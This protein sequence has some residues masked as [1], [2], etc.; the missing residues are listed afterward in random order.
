M[1]ISALK[2]FIDVAK[3]HPFPIQNLPYGIFSS[4]NNSNKRAGVAIGDFVLDLSLLEE[5]G[6]LDISHDGS[7]VFDQPHLN[8]FMAMGK[9]IWRQVR[10]CITQLLSH[11]NPA[12]RDNSPLRRVALVPMT[13]VTMHLPAKIG[14]Y[15][16]FYSSEYHASNV[17][18]MIRGSGNALQ[19][20]WKHLPVAYHGRASSVVLSGEAIH[21]P[22]GQIRPKDEEAPFVSPSQALD[23]EL[24]MA[25][26]TGQGNLLGHPI[27]IDEAE[28]KIFGLVLMNDWSA[29]DIQKWEYV[30]LG[31][32]LGK[33][34]ATSIS[35]WI[36]T[37]DAL[38]PFR[39]SGPEQSPQPLKY[40][41]QNKASSFDIQLQVDLA[42][43][44]GAEMILCESNFKYL[45]WSMAQQLA[46][47]TING[48]N[49]QPGDLLGSGTV[50]GPSE[51]S[52]GCLLE[53]SLK[54][55]ALPNGESRG[56]L[57]DG[58]RVTM[59]GWCQGDDYRV[60][61]GELIGTVLPSLK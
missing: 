28:D 32:F 10:E 17:G 40:L 23:F 12:L 41:Q 22:C 59:R 33:S 53:H 43:N 8:N 29:R 31:P 19:P 51:R 38:E 55:I 3:E 24:E 11:D 46:H 39:I 50:S 16:D 15:T 27:T 1:E 26:F 20:N 7:I 35:P 44:K 2:S 58:D 30:P 4:K 5:H 37:L 61:F 21:R 45:Y 42:T 25:F 9:S 14:D 54:P 48:C 49:I 36:V 18:A 47:H 13:E 56:Y 6:L 52:M 60:G 34:F 57:Q